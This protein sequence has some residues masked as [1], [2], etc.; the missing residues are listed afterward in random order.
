MEVD[1]FMVEDIGLNLLEETMGL[2][3]MRSLFAAFGLP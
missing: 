1:C 3:I 2:R